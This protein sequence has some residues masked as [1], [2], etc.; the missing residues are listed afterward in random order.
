MRLSVCQVG[1]SLL[2][3]AVGASPLRSVL[4]QYCSSSSSP[5]TPIRPDEA[6]ALFSRVCQSWLAGWQK[7]M[8]DAMIGLSGEW[9]WIAADWYAAPWPIHAH[10][11]SEG[12]HRPGLVA[13]LR[14]QRQ[15]RHVAK[16][17]VLDQSTRTS[18]WPRRFRRQ[19]DRLYASRLPFNSRQET[20]PEGLRGL[21]PTSTLH[22]H[23]AP[24]GYD[25]NASKFSASL[26][27]NVSDIS[28]SQS[29]MSS[30]ESWKS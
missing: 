22:A 18:F 15:S 2:G 20:H 17:A 30:G 12:L 3:A 1:G 4:T 26:S 25:R 29:S 6:M 7:K 27:L 11:S 24:A 10:G 13:I 23:T 19:F 14:R 5:P 16:L 21:T 8:C 9:F 28:T